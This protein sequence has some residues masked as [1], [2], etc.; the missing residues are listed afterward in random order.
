[1]FN[2][3]DNHSCAQ[4]DGKT[5]NYR[6]LNI[7]KETML[8][9][10]E[11]ITGQRGIACFSENVIENDELNLYLHSLHQMIM[12]GGE[13]FE[14]KKCS[15]SLFRCLSNNTDNFLR[16]VFQSAVKK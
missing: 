2:P 12:D 1:M 6:G 8:S 3:N 10:A 4:C 15:C 14:K 13:E 9:L 5:L 11:E 7:P 16:T